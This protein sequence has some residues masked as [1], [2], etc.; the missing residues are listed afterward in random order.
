[1]FCSWERRRGG[2]LRPK[3]PWRAIEEDDVDK[4][5]GEWLGS[6]LEEAPQSKNNLPVVSLLC[7]E[8]SSDDACNWV[9]VKSYDPA[10][11]QVSYNWY[12]WGL[13][14]V[15]DRQWPLCTCLS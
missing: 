2:E 10:L 7:W 1:M 5:V 9:Y 14:R 11:Q 6:W 12:D 4:T 15:L 8:G 3:A 13:G